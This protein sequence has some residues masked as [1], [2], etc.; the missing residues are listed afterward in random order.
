[1]DLLIGS[2]IREKTGITHSQLSLILLIN[3]TVF[4]DEIII[5]KHDK[6]KH[7]N[8]ESCEQRFMLFNLK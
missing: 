1:M 5:K 2:S 7:I 3:I 4:P 6:R 8:K